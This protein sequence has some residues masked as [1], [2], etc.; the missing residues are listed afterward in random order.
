MINPYDKF[1]ASM[2][3]K[4]KLA[5]LF[6]PRYSLAADT[7]NYNAKVRNWI[8]TYGKLVDKFPDKASLFKHLSENLI[9]NKP[10][11]YLEFGVAEGR[12]MQRWVSLNRHPD[13]R[14]FGF[15]SFAGLP[16]KWNSTYGTGAFDAGGKIPVIDDPRVRFIKGWFNDTLPGFLLEFN[17][18]NQLV[19]N[20]DSDLYSSTLYT[21]TMLD[22][23]I[24]TGTIIL[25]DEFS[26]PL[27]EFKALEDY[28]SAYKRQ[29]KPLGI[30]GGYAETVAMEFQ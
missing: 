16:E 12:S 6:W 5:A 26:S 22:K 14:F 29:V 2:A 9:G 15:D 17:P 28:L 3:K 10:I 27:H 11:D 4:K 20:N 13:S 8:K 21:L 24:Q 30:R 19:I 23:H 18:R 25:F 7:I 1:E